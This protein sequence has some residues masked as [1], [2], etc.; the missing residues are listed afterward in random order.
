MGRCGRSSDTESGCTPGDGFLDRPPESS[1]SGSSWKTARRVANP[2]Q[3]SPAVIT[4]SRAY[5]W[6]S[7]NRGLTAARNTG[8][9]YS[10][11]SLAEMDVVHRAVDAQFDE[12]RR[13][14]FSVVRVGAVGHTGD[15]LRRDVVLYVN[16]P[17]ARSTHETAPL[18][19]PVRR[20]R[21]TLL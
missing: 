15:V 10:T 12:V 11:Y 7:T 13:E 6:C 3:R 9:V 8:V 5:G 16:G 14:P 4:P 21:R 19:P 1:S 20:D 2:S 17:Q 18:L